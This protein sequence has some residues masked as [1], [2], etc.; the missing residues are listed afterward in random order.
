M[1]DPINTNDELLAG[2]DVWTAATRTVD[3]D[4]TTDSADDTAREHARLRKRHW[5]MLRISAFV[6]L[7]ACLLQTRPDHRVQFRFGPSFPLPETCG[8][9]VF[10]NVECPGCGLTRSFIS[11]SRGD[12]WTAW[13]LNRVSW[14]LALALLAQFPY[15]L[16]S[17]RQLERSDSARPTWP[18]WVGGFLVTVLV[19]NWVLKVLGI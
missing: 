7:M 2:T 18:N 1:S 14:L 12:I 13:K 16:W 15:R 8:S 19:G 17:I 11:L 6:I 3:T 9:K 10:F 4:T 5:W